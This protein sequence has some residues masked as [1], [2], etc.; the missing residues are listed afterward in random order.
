VVVTE[1]DRNSPA[2]QALTQGDVIESINRQPVRNTAE[3]NRLAAEAKGRTLLRVVRQG[4]GLFVVITPGAD[5]G[6]DD[7]GDQ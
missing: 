2:A 7:G 6:G 1:V 4:Q 5:S 3:F